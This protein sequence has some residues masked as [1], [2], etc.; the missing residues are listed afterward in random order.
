MG[1]GSLMFACPALWE[2]AMTV[3]MVRL[4][5]NVRRYATAAR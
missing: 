4:G 1:G 3:P 5:S 2:E